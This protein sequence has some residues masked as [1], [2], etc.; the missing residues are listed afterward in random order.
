[1][2]WV[3]KLGIFDNKGLQ[4]EDICRKGICSVIDVSECDKSIAILLVSF[5]T[6]TL[7]KNRKREKKRQEYLELGQKIDESKYSAKELPPTVIILEEGHTY[8]P[9]SGKSKVQSLE[10]LVTYI[11]E[12]RGLGLGLILI[13]QEP[14]QLNE[15][16]LTQTDCVIAHRLTARRDIK[17]VVDIMPGEPY[18]N[19]ELDLKTLNVGEAAVIIDGYL[20]ERVKIRPARTIHKQR[21]EY[22]PTSKADKE[23]I[24]SGFSISKSKSRELELSNYWNTL[25][26]EKKKQLEQLERAEKLAK[27]DKELDQKEKDLVKRKQNIEVKNNSKDEIELEKLEK[28]SD[29]EEIEVKEEKIEKKSKILN[30][31]VKE[32]NDMKSIT[33]NFAD[34]MKK[35]DSLIEKGQYNTAKTRASELKI[36]IKKIEDKDVRI[37]YE[38]RIKDVEK[39]VNSKLKK[40]MKQDK[41]ERKDEE[42]ESKFDNM[43]DKKKAKL[44][45]KD[46]EKS[47]QQE[48]LQER[49]DNKIY[50]IFLSNRGNNI[51]LDKLQVIT[52]FSLKSVKE[53]INRLIY[54]GIIEEVQSDYYT[55]I[56]ERSKRKLSK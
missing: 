21:T 39:I 25:E 8:L 24:K 11:K 45:Q 4:I 22:T 23:Q 53:S 36:I 56:K 35:I 33:E 14:G 29:E 47:K 9:K 27:R 17:T 20:P 1:M 37:E 16:A 19:F 42:Q 43:S 52:N 55:L 41:V 51:T 15:T 7:M 28:E 50:S 31:E 10:P 46:L 38:K 6:E 40:L 49:I 34:I 5:F 12:C 26:K 48:D 54:D 32:D 2:L 3:R 13:S 18:E 30:Q 44:E